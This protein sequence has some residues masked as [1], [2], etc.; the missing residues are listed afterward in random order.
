VESRRR[1]RR[2]AQSRRL[3]PVTSASLAGGPAAPRLRRIPPQRREPARLRH[4]PC[5]PE[6]RAP[7]PIAVRAP[8]LRRPGSLRADSPRGS[9]AAGQCLR[10]PAKRPEHVLRDPGRAGW[11]RRCRPVTHR[12]PGPADPA[13]A[14][15]RHGDSPRGQH[16]SPV[17]RLRG[18]P[19]RG[20]LDDR[21][22]GSWRCYA[23]WKRDPMGG[24]AGRSRQSSIT[25]PGGSPCKTGSYP[26]R[27]RRPH[28]GRSAALRATRPTP[29]R[30]V[31][32]RAC[33]ATPTA[34]RPSATRSSETWRWW[35]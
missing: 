29:R 10:V 4:G 8:L 35:T 26:A 24:P 27:R 2:K 25:T 18:E 19:A 12:A 32:T 3:D 20:R 1:W 33:C 30:T 23:R 9:G 14:P 11:G 6:G 15:G 34:A 17:F 5:D 16:G 31:R 7:A 22:K 28:R 13:H 21:S